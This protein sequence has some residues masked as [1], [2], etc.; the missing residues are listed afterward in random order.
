MTSVV[1]RF[2]QSIGG[3]PYLIEVSAVSKDRWRAHIARMPGVPTAM[4]P[5]YGRT[6]AEAA[7]QLSAWLTRA[8]ERTGGGGPV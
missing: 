7:A 3:R 5:F 2:E 6:P 1:H 8:H 4:M